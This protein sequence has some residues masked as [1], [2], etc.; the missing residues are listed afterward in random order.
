MRNIIRTATVVLG[1]IS[2]AL[3]QN[4]TS[5]CGQITERVVEF[6]SNQSN[7]PGKYFYPPVD[8]LGGLDEISNE[9]SSGGL[10]SQYAL[11]LALHNLVASAHEGH[12]GLGLCTRTPIGY[13]RGR[14]TIISFV[15]V[16]EDGTDAPSIYMVG[17]IA[18]GAS[19]SV[20]SVDLIDGQNVTQYLEHFS[21]DYP[22]DPDAA[23]NSV[24]WSFG[25]GQV[26]GGFHGSFTLPNIYKSINDVTNITY[27]NESTISYENYAITTAALWS[28]NVVDGE[29]FTQIY[30]INPAQLDLQSQS[31]ATDP[32]VPA[33]PKTTPN[34]TVATG[35]IVPT[36]L[37][38]PY[39]PVAKDV[40]NQVAGYFLNETEYQDTA[41]LY[42]S[43]FLN[44][45][46]PP[47]E[48]PDTFVDAVMDFIS[49]CTT[50]NKTKLIID[51]SGNPGGNPILPYDLF[52][53]LFPN[54]QPEGRSR[55]R[56]NPAAEI[57]GETW[58]NVP[59]ELLT[60]NST[61][62]ALFAQLKT[63]ALFSPFNYRSALDAE[64]QN[65]TGWTSG[66]IPYFP[67][68]EDKGDN[69]TAIGRLP[70]NNTLF[71]ET[72]GGF[73]PYGYANGAEMP[74]PF[75]AQNIV[76]L[77]DGICASACS[78]LANFL[79]N[80]ANVKTIAVGGR[81]QKAPMQAV[82]GTKGS[83]AYPYQSL[84]LGS[85]YIDYAEVRPYIPEPAA[86][87]Y[88]D[89]LPGF[90]PLPLGSINDLQSYSINLRDSIPANDEAGVPRQFIFEPADCKIFYTART[91]R[92]PVALWEHVYDVAWKGK[93][94]AWGG[95]GEV[96]SSD[97]S[98]AGGPAAG[99][100]ATEGGEDTSAAGRSAYVMMMLCLGM[101]FWV[102]L[103][104]G[105]GKV[106]GTP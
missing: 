34:R 44:S 94:C 61:D 45:T 43:S 41:V 14:E 78:I 23:W 12:L 17:D 81:P 5:P 2:D 29:S 93:P 57:Y 70:L 64:L 86:N 101:F 83:Q 98:G 73:V 16:S 96:G 62:S 56:V 35:A 47:L 3:S 28:S 82:G 36:L 13:Q 30:C 33:S 105:V 38:Y 1:I 55:L 76:L 103:V 9:I 66:E 40:N 54:I 106:D 69:F 102:G 91:V 20:S 95:M 18:T 6:Y 26:S 59:E 21:I 39:Y 4:T 53:R 58:G 8:L 27:S 80:Q 68:V 99:G 46:A 10:S 49:A 79:T 72:L 25:R 24:F 7:P 65:F 67:P 51:V 85:A 19:S 60:I 32:S 63:T 74:Q 48:A 90:R 77:T 89:I 15:S 22:A 97:G 50:A 84:I 92:D 75:E 88:R 71:D 37:G 31:S 52:N 87:T 104:G 100:N 11:D 42:I